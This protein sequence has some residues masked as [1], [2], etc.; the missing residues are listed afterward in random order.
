VSDS[1]AKISN[2]PRPIARPFISIFESY[3]VDPVPQAATRLQHAAAN[4]RIR[5]AHTDMLPPKQSKKRLVSYS[6]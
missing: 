5:F 1:A 6:S 2:A 3:L 4:E